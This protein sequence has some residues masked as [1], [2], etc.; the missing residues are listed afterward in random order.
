MK[1]EREGA[2]PSKR[3]RASGNSGGPASKSSRKARA[4]KDEGVVERRKPV[5][6]DPAGEQTPPGPRRGRNQDAG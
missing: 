6:G 1:R 4:A 5:T 2:A 3:R